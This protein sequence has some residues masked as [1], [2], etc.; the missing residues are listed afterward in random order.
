MVLEAEAV[1]W[2]PQKYFKC[3]SHKEV[4][5]MDTVITLVMAEVASLIIEVGRINIF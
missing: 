4:V 1:E 5:V 3:S 2:I